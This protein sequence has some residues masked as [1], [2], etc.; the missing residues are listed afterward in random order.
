MANHKLNVLN[1]GS[2]VCTRSLKGDGIKLYRSK[3]TTQKN[4]DYLLKHHQEKPEYQAQ[5]LQKYNLTNEITCGVTLAEKNV[6]SCGRMSVWK[7]HL[8]G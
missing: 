5:I 8:E 7:Q 4:T 6:P 2:T 3:K 1:I